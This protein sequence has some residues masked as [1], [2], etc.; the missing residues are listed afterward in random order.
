MRQLGDF[1]GEVFSLMG[2]FYKL[3]CYNQ[4]KLEVLAMLVSIVKKYWILGSLVIVM[5]PLLSLQV[6]DQSKTFV[7]P[8]PQILSQLTAIDYNNRG[9]DKDDAGD[10]QGA[11]A[12]YN[13][14]IKL[15]RDYALAYY[16]RGI[17]KRKLG[18]YQG[19]IADYNQAIKLKP[20]DADAYNNRG[21]SKK[22]LGDYQGAIADY[23]QAITLNPDYTLAYNN[24]V[25]IKNDNLKDYQGAIA[26]YNQAIKL[27]PDYAKAYNNRGNSKRKLGDDQGAVNDYRQAAKL[28]QQQNKMQ[29]YQDAINRLKEL[30]ISN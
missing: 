6:L 22:N 5:V 19:A 25:A 26:D 13:Q 15:K 16:N 10:Y 4:T 30:G 1:R 8:Q 2:L 21:V 29:D 3:Y 20:D 14:A 24:R 18:D 12:D 23:N 28:Y 7:Q 27:N 11:I 17:S 9:F